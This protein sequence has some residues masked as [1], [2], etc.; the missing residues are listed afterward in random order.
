MM[1]AKDTVMDE[2]NM[3]VI[4]RDACK[5]WATSKNEDKDGFLLKNLED[6]KQDFIAQAQAE[7]SFKMGYNQALKDIKA[8]LMP[9]DME[10]LND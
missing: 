9:S 10:G 4:L 8:G 5:Y 6:V 7:I 1:E 3:R 2:V